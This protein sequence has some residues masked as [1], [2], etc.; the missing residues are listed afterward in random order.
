[1]IFLIHLAQLQNNVGSDPSLTNGVSTRRPL[2]RSKHTPYKC[3]KCPC[4][5]AFSENLDAHMADHCRIEAQTNLMISSDSASRWMNSDS[6]MLHS[7][8]TWNLKDLEGT[9]ASSSNYD[10]E[11]SNEDVEKEEMAHEKAFPLANNAE[12]EGQPTA[13]LD[14][15]DAVSSIIKSIKEVAI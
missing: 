5:F 7:Q 11:T 6:P 2:H 12:N 15:E 3:P 4:E 14:T 1:M 9:E 10:G 8:F 13:N